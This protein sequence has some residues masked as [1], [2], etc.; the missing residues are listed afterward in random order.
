MQTHA[1]TAAL[2]LKYALLTLSTLNTK[3]KKNL[4]I[5]LC[6]AGLYFK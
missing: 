2:A 6:N 3:A 5:A 1:Q 4:N